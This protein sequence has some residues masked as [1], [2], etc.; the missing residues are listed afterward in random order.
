MNPMAQ[1]GRGAPLPSSAARA[2]PRGGRLNAPAAGGAPRQRAPVPSASANPTYDIESAHDPYASKVSRARSTD[3]LNQSAP[4][5]ST[6]AKGPLLYKLESPSNGEAE[7]VCP[8]PMDP[9]FCGNVT[10]V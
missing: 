4:A 2:S 9:C 8:Q 5:S 6:S 1:Q 3:Q 7:F 10:Q